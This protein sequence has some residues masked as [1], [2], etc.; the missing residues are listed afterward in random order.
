[1][2]GRRRQITRRSVGNEAKPQ[3]RTAEKVKRMREPVARRSVRSS[4]HVRQFHRQREVLLL[5]RKA[6]V[7]HHKP[8]AIG[9]VHTTRVDVGGEV[10]GPKD[11][12][13]GKAV[14][15]TVGRQLF[16]RSERSSASSRR[17]SS[18]S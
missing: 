14:R 11:R 5:R 18:T 13:I 12:E 6:F 9:K 16:P 3:R 17:L 15:R 7:E 2:P 8:P 1:M 10:V 4:L